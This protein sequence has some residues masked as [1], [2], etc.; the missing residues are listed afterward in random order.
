VSD[1]SFKVDPRI[2]YARQYNIS[3]YGLERLHPFDSRKYGRAYRALRQHY[4]RDL[5]SR[6]IRP[7]GPASEQQLLAVHTTQYLA[8]LKNSTYL[9]TALELPPLARVPAWITNLHVLRPMRWATAGTV[10][11][12]REA[13]KHH[14]VFNL[15]GGYHHAGPESGEG[16]CI[17]SDI[18]LAIDTLR[19]DQLLGP[20][21]KVAYI[22]TDAHQGNGVCHAFFTDPRVLIYD[23]YNRSIYPAAD[24]QAKRRIDCNVPLALNRSDAEYLSAL[25]ATLPPFLDAINRVGDARL[26]IHNAGTDIYRGDPLGAMGVSERGIQK[27]DAFVLAQLLER[28][29]PTVVLPSGGYTRESY[30]FIADSIIAAISR[31]SG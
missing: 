16:F 26:A 14:L 17:Y 10:L 13:M 3:F 29:I 20:H 2:V 21:D 18:A 22:D 23:I 8:R 5:R 9:A 24:A 12:A 19:Q 1:T 30:R 27:R 28:R 6:V 11:A 25:E 7:D 15:S 31:W 4:G